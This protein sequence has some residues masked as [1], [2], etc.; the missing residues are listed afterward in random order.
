MCAESCKCEWRLKAENEY[1]CVL[2]KDRPGEQCQS[3]YECVYYK[4]GE[5]QEGSD[6][7][8]YEEIGQL[9]NLETGELYPDSEN[10]GCPNI[11]EIRQCSTI[12]RLLLPF[13]S[14]WNAIIVIIVIA[15]VYY[16]LRNKTN[17]RKR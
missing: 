7:F 4:I 5:C 11:S 12:Q 8:V 13:F 10:D 3:T 16:L 6:T 1:E 15:V 17:K 2:F 9:R 14:I